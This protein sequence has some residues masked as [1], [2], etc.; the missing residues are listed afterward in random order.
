M[1]E[2]N[3]PEYKYWIDWS[4]IIGIYLV[5]LGHGSLVSSEIKTFIYSFHMPLFFI[6]SGL[7]YKRRGF[8]DT[9]VKC[10]RSL[11]IPY[12]IINT[13]LLLLTIGKSYILDGGCTMKEIASY[14]IPIFIGL[15]YK[16]DWL[17]PLCP[18]LWFLIALFCI[19]LM[20]SLGRTRLFNF[21]LSTICI[22]LF[23]YLNV[24]LAIDLWFPIDSAMLALPFFV[25]GYEYKKY[26]NR[27]VSVYCVVLLIAFL[28]LVNHYNGRIDIDLCEIGNSLFLFYLGGLLGS[29]CIMQISRY[30]IKIG[31][32]KEY[33]SGTILILG[34]NLMS[35][36]FVKNIW[37][38]IFPN[39][40][41]SSLVGVLLALVIC[42]G[43]IP[44]I[45]FCK[46]Y[47]S[48]ILGY[49]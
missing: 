44:F 32:I 5:T 26:F 37:M 14:V 2:I 28:I 3:T 45:K 33:S 19:Q 24:I 20:M 25:I 29:I 23:Y 46:K 15:G 10:W 4:K 8:K 42:V 30:L 22:G 38:R 47:F 39:I 43:F 27:D 36:N 48:P 41:I 12:F 21:I 31:G 1:N 49:R 7:L 9:F 17:T 6:I 11:I 13:I 18:P 35:I 16:V 34:F 40:E